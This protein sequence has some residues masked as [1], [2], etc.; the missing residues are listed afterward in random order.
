MIMYLLSCLVHDSDVPLQVMYISIHR[1]DGGN[2]FPGTGAPE[3][4]G[5][6]AGV[7]TNANIAWSV[8][9]SCTLVAVLMTLTQLMDTIMILCRGLC[10]DRKDFPVTS[11]YSRS[12]SDNPLAD[13][14]YLAAMRAIVL[15]LIKAFRLV[16]ITRSTYSYSSQTFHDPGVSWL[17][18]RPRP[19]A[20]PGR[21]QRLSR[22]LWLPHLLPSQPGVCFLFQA[23]PSISEKSATTFPG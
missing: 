19:R 3:E 5:A 20:H 15:P 7:G 21:L 9:G 2:F 23:D 16:L 4:T 14:E 11:W 22:L 13:A 10:V 12:A 1:H 17:R 6:G 18:R 8:G